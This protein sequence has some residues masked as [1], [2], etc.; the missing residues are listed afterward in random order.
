MRPRSSLWTFLFGVTLLVSGGC[1]SGGSP[2]LE[3]LV[4]AGVPIP[5]DALLKVMKH[6]SV[7]GL[8]IA[9]IHGGQIDWARGYGV[10]EFGQPGRV[11]TSTLF[12]A[13]SISKPVSTVVALRLVERNELALDEDVNS[14]LKSWQVPASE[15]TRRR[16]VTLRG[17]L[18]HSAGLTM[19]GVPEFAAEAEL[20]T[21][22][23]ILDGE[24]SAAAEPVRLFAEPG[25]TY[26]YSGGGYIVLQVLLTDVTGRFFAPLAH[27]LVLQPAG[28]SSSTF[29]QPLPQHL[30]PNAA[31]GHLASGTPLEGSW[32]TLPEQAAG[33]L[34]TTP[35]DLAS[36]MLELWRSYQGYSDNLLPR[37]LARLML[38]RQ[39]DDFG[40]GLSLP[41]AGVFRFQHG[42]GNA[43][44][45][46]HMV[47][48]VHVP[49]GVV[50]M[51]NGDAGEQVI[52]EV[53]GAIAHA[54]GW[55]A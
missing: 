21:L 30:R 8:S 15:F 13:A 37:R 11:D 27:E 45:R 55:E 33:G 5:E 28:M 6:H 12:Q 43:G 24:F 40:L 51:T 2:A 32:H 39:I 29:E 46:C 1:T 22:V 16:P 3:G 49:E 10:R 26:R 41:S 34:W 4:N 7:P 38:T 42:G 14:K 50:I 9:V 25:T 31:V 19:H 35:T 44:Y 20:P 52:W 47:L 53:F 36:F 17:L 23:E 54:Y 18:S 48:S